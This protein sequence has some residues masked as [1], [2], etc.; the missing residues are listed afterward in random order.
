MLLLF[1]YSTNFWQT[2][3]SLGFATSCTEVC[4]QSLTRLAAGPHYAF[5]FSKIF[6][7]NI[8]PTVKL[9]LVRLAQILVLL[10]LHYCYLYNLYDALAMQLCPFDPTTHWVLSA[11][12][13]QSGNP[14]YTNIQ[15]WTWHIR[16]LRWCVHASQQNHSSAHVP[17]ICGHNTRDLRVVLVL[18]I[19]MIGPWQYCT[20]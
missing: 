13:S 17:G 20:L 14:V 16:L 10:A 11:L 6:L 7:N 3:H 15:H 12:K 4:F 2:V 9:I 19:I 5:A 1:L 18:L 8:A